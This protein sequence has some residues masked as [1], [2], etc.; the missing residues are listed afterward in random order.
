M[1]SSLGSGTD[2][3][4]EAPCGSDPHYGHLTVGQQLEVMS[5]NV[6]YFQVNR[7][8]PS[9]GEYSQLGELPYYLPDFKR[10]RRPQEGLEGKAAWA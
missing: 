3:P 10:D 6:G 1:K 7:L 8:W 9:L 5:S 2:H 4:P